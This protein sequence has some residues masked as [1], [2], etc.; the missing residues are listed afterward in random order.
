MTNIAPIALAS[1]RKAYLSRINQLSEKSVTKHF[2]AYEDIA[3]NDPH[4]QI[5]LDDPRFEK[6]GDDVLGRTDWY[7]SQ[8]APLRARI[9]LHHVA[10]Q[11]KIGIDFEAVLSRGLLEFTSSLP[12]GAPEFRYAYHEIVEEGQHSMMFQEFVNR[13]G[14]PVKGL[15]GI[16]G[17]TSRFVPA[18][19]RTFPELFF[20]FVLGGETPI[21]HVQRT[22][23][24]ETDLHPLLRRVMQIHVTE[25][26]RH[27]CFAKTYLR[28]HVPQLGALRRFQLAV[29]APIILSQMARQMLAPPAAL[30]RTYG[31]PKSVV[32]EAYLDNPEHHAQVI[33]GLEPIRSLCEELGLITGLPGALWRALGLCPR[34]TDQTRL[35]Q[36]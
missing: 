6:T 36:A 19:G 22:A 5:Y 32:R 4:F 27:I 34:A 35:L 8:P 17:F 16:V 18:F 28:E 29:R 24:A 15:E 11:M 9:G 26:A 14:L 3:W 31:I 20:L 1:H 13:T 7:R 25:E 2:D 12:N 30:V 33:A 10:A 21:D 23:L